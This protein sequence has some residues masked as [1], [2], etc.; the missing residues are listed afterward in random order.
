MNFIER[1]LSF[2]LALYQQKNRIADLE[3]AL[4]NGWSMSENGDLL[5]PVDNSEIGYKIPENADSLLYEVL[6][7]NTK[8][9]V[10]A[11]TPASYVALVTSADT[12]LEAGK[13]GIDIIEKCWQGI[14][15]ASFQDIHAIEAEKVWLRLL[16]KCVQT[17]KE[18]QSGAKKKELKQ[19]E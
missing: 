6:K 14:R 10:Y 8:F 19:I 3:H 5:E 9:A 2:N 12:P 16:N 7:R 18:E 17:I 1:M 15:D 13:I 4:K 11:E